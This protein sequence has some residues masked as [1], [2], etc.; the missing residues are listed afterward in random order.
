M[1]LSMST[2]SVA[3]AT[4]TQKQTSINNSLSQAQ[5]VVANYEQQRKDI[6]TELQKTTDP[7]RRRTRDEVERR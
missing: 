6:L 5:G 4:L 3:S 7:W 1:Q 2:N